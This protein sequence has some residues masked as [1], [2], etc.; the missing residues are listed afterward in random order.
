M[1]WRN[2]PWWRVS[3]GP[4]TGYAKGFHGLVVDD[5]WSCLSNQV[6]FM[7]N[8]PHWVFCES[9]STFTSKLPYLD[10]EIHFFDRKKN[11]ISHLHRVSPALPLKTP[12]P[13]FIKNG[14]QIIGEFSHSTKNDGVCSPSS[15]I[16]NGHLMVSFQH[17]P[18]K[19]KMMASSR[20][21]PVA[22]LGDLAARWTNDTFRS[23][24]H[25]VMNLSKQ[26]RFSVVCLGEWP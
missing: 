15:F 8:S 3:K 4:P 2:A 24:W 22:N 19:K 1:V 7:A 14:H 18:I 17:F 5:L 13:S 10:H 16:K 26:P 12:I 11:C 21:T 6:L 23:S 9:S 20:Y 25:R